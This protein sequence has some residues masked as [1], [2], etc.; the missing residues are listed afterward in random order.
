MIAKN[1][2]FKKTHTV[3]V[4]QVA[5]LEPK[6]WV[7]VLGT[8]IN[9]GTP[10][11]HQCVSGHKQLIRPNHVLKGIGCELCARTQRGLKKRL[12]QDQ[13]LLK[14]KKFHGSSITVLGK[15]AGAFVKIRHR[16]NTCSFIWSV[17]PDNVANSSKTGCPKCISGTKHSKKA[18]RWLRDEARRRG[19]R[20]RHAENWGEYKIPGTRMQV[21]GFHKPSNTIFEFYG[22]IFHGNPALFKP[23]QKCHPYSTKTAGRLYRDTIKREEILVSLGYTVISIWEKDYDD[24]VRNRKKY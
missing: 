16:C 8:Y 18:I 23:R 4:E 22:D 14:V 24:Q 7:K 21:D 10:I 20:I 6:K 11:L 15:Y 12:T 3:Y 5:S 9:D 2:G 1:P 17:S 19:I 13:Y